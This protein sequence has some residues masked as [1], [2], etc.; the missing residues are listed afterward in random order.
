MHVV[1]AVTP[2][3]ALAVLLSQAS[4]TVANM[5]PSYCEV[6]K[7]RRLVHILLLPAHRPRRLKYSAVLS[8]EV[9]R[10]IH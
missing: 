1:L 3:A 4:V 9:T 7:V 5:V 2:A 8:G 10:R 6:L